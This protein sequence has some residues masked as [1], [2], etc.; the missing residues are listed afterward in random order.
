MERLQDKYRLTPFS[1]TPWIKTLTGGSDDHAGLFIGQTYTEAEAATPAD[2]LECLKAK[3]TAAGGRSNDFRS[4]AF[5]LY[6]IAYD[7]SQSQSRAQNTH[8]W[9]NLLH[10]LVFDPK[11]LGVRNRL[12]LNTL[13][14]SRPSNNIHQHFR[15]LLENLKLLKDFRAEEK[16]PLVYDR[17]ASIS[18]E[19]FRLLFKSFERDLKK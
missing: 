16:L 9:M 3:K 2:F 7:F 10:T 6:K 19:F 13:K 5:T 11:P 15:G 17:L 12:K 14:W 8:G 4:F 18:D 1:N